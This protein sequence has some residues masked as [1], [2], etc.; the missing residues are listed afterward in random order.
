MDRIRSIFLS[1]KNNSSQSPSHEIEIPRNHEIHH[2]PSNSA[3]LEKAHTASEPQAVITA[4][5]HYRFLS[6]I[7]DSVSNQ[8]Q[9]TPNNSNSN[10]ASVHPQH[11]GVKTKRNVDDLQREVSTLN[12]GLQ[13]KSAQIAEM[14]RQSSSTNTRLFA[15]EKK[16]RQLTQHLEEARIAENNLA[17]DRKTV[18]DQTRQIQ[19][20]NIEIRDYKAQ[21]DVNR[22]DFLQQL[23]HEREQNKLLSAAL[24]SEQ[25]ET[26][27]KNTNT[28]EQIELI[29]AQSENEELRAELHECKAQIKVNHTEYLRELAQEQERYRALEQDLNDHKTRLQAK[30]PSTI[31]QS[32]LERAHAEN[33]ELRTVLDECKAQIFRSQ[34]KQQLTDSE[35]QV[36]YENLNENVSD[37]VDRQFAYADGFLTQSNLTKVLRPHAAALK[38][39]LPD[40]K[41]FV[42]EFYPQAEGLF[43]EKFVHEMLVGK[44]G[45]ARYRF[46]GLNKGVEAF[47]DRVEEGMQ[48]CQGP[49]GMS[50]PRKEVHH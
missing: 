44:F 19:E 33:Q 21:I 11:S 45:G 10:S 26:Q 43:T 2:L 36:M 27:A 4:M 34:P 8:T 28:T 49:S 29:D 15:A 16:V 9:T 5:P 20:L 38:T 6:P 46:P 13:K 39:I 7:G 40:N 17:E 50:T 23:T 30:T 35:M 3:R 41:S 31:E 47:L 1:M 32:E 42:P 25:A 14:R 37:W 18:V 48:L 12:R 24:A 22:A